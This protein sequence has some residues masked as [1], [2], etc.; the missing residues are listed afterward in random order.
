I[1]CVLFFLMPWLFGDNHDARTC[2]ALA[3]VGKAC[4]E[5]DYADRPFVRDVFRAWHDANSRIT[6]PM[7]G[8]GTSAVAPPMIV[9]A[10]AGGASRAAYFT[11]QVLGEIA[12]R[13]E[14]FAERLF[15]MS[16]VSGGSLGATVF[17]SLV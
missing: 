10:T 5:K 13:E 6:R 3:A 4:E 14:N 9:V 12:S 16:G 8:Q 11:T 1:A 7:D 17:R 15:L 2:R